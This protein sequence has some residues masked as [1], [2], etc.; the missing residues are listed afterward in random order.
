MPFFLV[1]YQFSRII[2]WNLE[3]S[4]FLLVIY[5]QSYINSQT[6][7]YSW[8][9][10]NVGFKR[11]SIN[12]S[13]SQWLAAGGWFSPGT[14]VS[15]TNKTDRHDISEILLKVALNTMVYSHLVYSHLVYSH[16][17]Y[18]RKMIVLHLV[19]SMNFIYKNNI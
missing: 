9:T 5:T 6:P 13:T 3:F 1:R 11:Q 12:L 10:G 16:L 18:S 17:V 7:P 14:P 4:D 8:N 2:Q 15:S 19:Y